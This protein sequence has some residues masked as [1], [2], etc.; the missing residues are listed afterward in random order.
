MPLYGPVGSCVVP[1]DLVK[2]C[3]VLYGF[4]WSFYSPAWHC[5]AL[6][7]T[8]FFVN[9]TCGALWSVLYLFG[10]VGVCIVPYSLAWSYTV[11]LPH[12]PC[13]VFNGYTMVL[14]GPEW[15][16]VLVYESLLSCMAL[17]C[18][19]CSNSRFR[20]FKVNQHIHLKSNTNACLLSTHATF[21]QVLCLFYFKYVSN[22]FLF[23]C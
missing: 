19:I 13:V 21:A 20:K 9:V 14:Y 4:K 22:K 10:P 7:T 23:Q 5:M 17:Y 1:N 11:P 2:P 15:S 3:L 6:Y 18:P 8:L 16:Y 12:G